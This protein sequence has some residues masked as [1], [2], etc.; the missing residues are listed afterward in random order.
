MAIIKEIFMFFTGL[1][2][3]AKMVDGINNK[4]TNAKDKVINLIEIVVSIILTFII[5]K[6]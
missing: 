5:F 4:Y 1:Y 2:A 6:I 3:L